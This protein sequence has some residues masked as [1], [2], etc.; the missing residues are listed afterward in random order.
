MDYIFM[1]AVIANHWSMKFYPFSN[2]LCLVHV[3]IAKDA[4][5]YV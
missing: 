1:K 2:V 4:T 5:T 3:T